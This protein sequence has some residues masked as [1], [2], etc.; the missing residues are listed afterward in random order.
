MDETNFKLRRLYNFKYL[1]K[2]PQ[3]PENGKYILLYGG[4][5]ECSIH[6]R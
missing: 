3:C 4:V 5:P 6:G 1:K 2:I